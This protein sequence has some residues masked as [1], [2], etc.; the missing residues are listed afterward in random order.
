MAMMIMMVVIKIILH[1]DNIDDHN[2]IVIN[3]TIMFMVFV[4]I[5]NIEKDI[6]DKNNED[7][8]E[9]MTS[10]KSDQSHDHAPSSSNDLHSID[11]KEELS[12]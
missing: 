2:L 10:F 7:H 12:G 4:V 9:S 11:N 6:S 1:G 5:L 3:M 8:F